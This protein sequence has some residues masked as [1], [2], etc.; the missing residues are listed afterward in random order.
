MSK[1][2]EVLETSEGRVHILTKNRWLYVLPLPH[3][4]VMPH[5][6]AKLTH[7]GAFIKWTTDDPARLKALHD[8][9]VCL[10]ENVRLSGL[11]EVANSAKMTERVWKTLG[12]S[13]SGLYEIVNQA[14]KGRR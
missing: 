13:G 6:G 10:V 4:S 11:V 9:I 12:G 7:L 1:Y 8:A 14:A 3:T 2:F 5:S